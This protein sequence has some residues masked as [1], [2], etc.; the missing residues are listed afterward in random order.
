MELE[1]AKRKY[2]HAWGTLGSSWGISRTMAQIHALLL[3]STEPMSTDEIME[4]LTISRGNVNMNIRTLIDW[5][6]IE[7]VLVKGDRK[8]YFKSEKDIMQLGIQVAKERKKREL[9]PIL[10]ILAEV[11]E[12][13]GDSKETKEFRKVTSDLY[14][15]AHQAEGFLNTFIS[16]NKSWFFKI[17]TKIKL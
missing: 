13:K 10:K 2:I 8:E 15:F 11:K 9:E 6:L 16:A 5:G 17:L 1:E 12:L 4:E 7:K 14:D 3:V